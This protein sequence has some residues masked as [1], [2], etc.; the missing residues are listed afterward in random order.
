MMEKFLHECADVVAAGAGNARPTVSAQVTM[1]EMLNAV[2]T[3]G[4]TPPAWLKDDCGAK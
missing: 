2:R 1:L 4:G 3:A